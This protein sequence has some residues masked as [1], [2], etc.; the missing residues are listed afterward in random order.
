MPAYFWMKTA[1]FMVSRRNRE[2]AEI[3]GCFGPK[4]FDRKILIIRRRP[5]GGGLFSNVNHVLQGVIHAYEHNMVPVV[6]MKNYSTEYSVLRKFHGTNNAW[7]YFFEQVSDV[8]LGDAYNSNDVTLSKGDRIIEFGNMAGRNL[9]FAFDFKSIESLNTV[10]EKHIKL[11]NFT[12]GYINYIE[13][14]FEIETKDTLGVFLRGK[15]Y[16]LTPTAGH[17]KQPEIDEVIKDVQQ[18]LESKS[19]TKIF[20][21]TDD[22]KIRAVFNNRFA[23][24]IYPDIRIDYETNF[25]VSIRKAFKIPKGVLAKNISYLSEIY[26]LSKLDYN[27]ASL[28]NG[29]A[30]LH[31]IN[32]GKFK[33]SKLYNLGVN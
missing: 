11:N 5:P 26:T 15:D 13:K 14:V 4:N 25:S 6:D 22:P 9:S 33:D 27:I 21:S 20:L 24:R 29:S 18:Y 23:D 28:S 1:G 8:S 16:I 3:N 10:Y 12:I 17:P 30:I 32:G 19:I 7:E 2:Y 31:V